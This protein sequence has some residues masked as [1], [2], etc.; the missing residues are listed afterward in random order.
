MATARKAKARSRT[1]SS[2]SSSRQSAEGPSVSRKSGTRTVAPRPVLQWACAGLG[3]LLTLGA[4][5]VI[6]VE[7]FSPERPASLRAEIVR[8]AP[9]TAGWIADVKVA[10]TGGRTAASVEIEGRVDDVAAT[11]TI[12]YVPGDGEAEAH[13]AF[14]RSPEPPAPV[15]RVMGWS[16]P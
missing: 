12:D 1:A 10:N 5:V 6:G 9:D 13:L 15:V 7:A 3:V 2:P 14:P 8:I 11:A 16:E 4:A